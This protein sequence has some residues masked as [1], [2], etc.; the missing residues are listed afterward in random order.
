[1]AAATKKAPEK[2]ARKVPDFS[3]VPGELVK[4]DGVELTWGTRNR[5]SPYDALLRQLTAA[6]PGMAL[7]FGSERAWASV[8]VRARKLNIR[9]EPA[10]ADGVLYVRLAPTTSNPEEER[11]ERHAAVLRAVKSR[12]MTHYEIGAWLRTN[13]RISLDAPLIESVLR[14]LSAA[15][16]VELRPDGKWYRP[17]K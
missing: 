9:V 2:K 7:K 14:Q 8:L 17:G 4:V 15:G 5:K 12:P 11:A 6:E 1:M 16:K 10:F 3:G 13:E